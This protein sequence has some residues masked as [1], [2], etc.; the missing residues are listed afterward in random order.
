MSREVVTVGPTTP[1][2]DVARLLSERKI[3][4]MPVCDDGQVL[5]VVSEADI[6]WRE[7]GFGPEKGRVLRWLVE[8]A[9]GDESRLAARTAGDAMSSPA[10]TIEPRASAARA[11]RL[12]VERHVKRL[13]VVADGRLVGIL[14]RG[15]LVRAFHRSDEEI[16]TEIRDDV[17]LRVLWVDPETLDVR[18]DDGEVTLAGMVET[19]TVAEVVDAFVRRVPGVVGVTSSLGWRVDDLSRR[20]RRSAAH[21]HGPGRF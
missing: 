14:S 1:L 5:G 19:R 21:A 3:S 9:G 8:Q 10:V 11:A 12:M 7:Q 13:P 4:G 18:V 16:E 20:T 17:L 2:K 15:D 6:V